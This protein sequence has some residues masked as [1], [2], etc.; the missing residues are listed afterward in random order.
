MTTEGG[1]KKVISSAKADSAEG[2]ISV[3]TIDELRDVWPE[4]FKQ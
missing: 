4:I 3:Q 2:Y 1:V